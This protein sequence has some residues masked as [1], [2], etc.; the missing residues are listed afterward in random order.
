[1]GYTI[2]YDGSDPPRNQP[3]PLGLRLS[4]LT[5]AFFLT[6]LLLTHIFWPSGREKLRQL[7]LPGDPDVTAQA[8][9]VM[10]DDLRS[11]EP[12]GEAVTVFCREILS[13]AENRP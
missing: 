9:S 11:G 8:F 10:M 12:M 5:A 2:R 7:L 3:G 6:F 1:M 4:G 13:N